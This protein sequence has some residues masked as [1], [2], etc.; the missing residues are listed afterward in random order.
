MSLSNRFFSNWLYALVESGGR[1]ALT[2]RNGHRDKAADRRSGGGV[3]EAR[4]T[5]IGQFA[6]HFHRTLR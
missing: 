3:L 2:R 6:T 4:D 5:N 1:E